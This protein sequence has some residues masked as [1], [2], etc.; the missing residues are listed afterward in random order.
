MVNVGIM[1]IP[2]TSKKIDRSRWRHKLVRRDD[3]R[4]GVYMFE[5]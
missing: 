3:L 2:S 1:F 4:C 5:I